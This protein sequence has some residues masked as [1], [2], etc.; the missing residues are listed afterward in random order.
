MEVDCGSSVTV[1]SKSKYFTHFK[2]PLSKYD[3]QLIVVNGEKLRVEGEA[4]VLVEF[5]GVTA[6]LQLL[7]LNCSND[8]TPLMGRTWLD[9]FFKDWRYFFLKLVDC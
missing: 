8:F 1:I 4:K 6:Q 7:V 5:K 3:K 9:V 2:D